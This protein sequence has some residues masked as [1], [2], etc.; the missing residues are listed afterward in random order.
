M[1][2]RGSSDARADVLIAGGGIAALE[3]V[4]ALKALAGSRTSITL[5]SPD[6]LFR[7]RPAATVEAFQEAP[8][9][10][11]DLRR[12]A[13][14]LGTSYHQARLESVAAQERYVR[15]ASGARL[16]Y[17]ALILAIGARP[18]ASIPGALVFRDQ[19]EV[20]LLRSL[21]QE[22]EEG[23]V[24]SVAFAVPSGATWPLPLY[25]LALLCA[26]RARQFGIDAA[27]SLVSPEREPLAIFGRHASRQVARLLEE[28]D[29]RFFGESIAIGV[30]RDGSLALQFDGALKADRVVTV[31]QLRGRRI[32]GVP[33]SWWGFVPTDLS[34]RVEGLRD[35]YAAGDMT[36]FPVKQGGL[37]AQQADRIANTIAASLDAAPWTGRSNFA[38]QARLL[39]GAHPLFLRTE[40]DWQ[41]HPTT[42]TLVHA[43]SNG[44]QAG[45]KVFGRYLVPYLEKLEQADDERRAPSR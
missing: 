31:P 30:R 25:E 28:R 32:G 38:L 16:S 44:A 45:T 20:P 33:A 14:D 1:P 9:R 19:R 29:V 41:G 10:T 24:S 21:L 26:A 23:V 11:Y 40:L 4:L 34:G 8:P 22:L 37:A 3:A 43:E 13:S 17:D 18:V 35:V 5:I 27:V 7:Y 15:L 2:A 6:P 12:I 36:T 39:G 42:A